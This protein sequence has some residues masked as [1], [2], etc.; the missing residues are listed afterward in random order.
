LRELLDR[1]A[2]LDHAELRFCS[3]EIE[4]FREAIAAAGYPPASVVSTPAALG[5]TLA[6]MGMLALQTG[7]VTDA[8]AVDA[9]Y[10][11]ASDAELFWKA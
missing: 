6:R 11:R 9:N 1:V 10:I 4:Q 7:S 5:A 8:I 3:P 2:G